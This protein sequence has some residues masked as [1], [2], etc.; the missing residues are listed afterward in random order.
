MAAGV[1]LLLCRVTFDF[2][3]V[4]GQLCCSRS[5]AG[6]WAVFRVGWLSS[7]TVFEAC[8]THQVP[9]NFASLFLEFAVWL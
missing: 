4:V 2:S 5:L 9:A 6:T 1:W 8:I 7:C 3:S